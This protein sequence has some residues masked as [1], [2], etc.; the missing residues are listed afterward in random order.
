MLLLLLRILLILQELDKNFT[1]IYKNRLYF[2]EGKNSHC[3]ETK[4]FHVYP[5]LFIDDFV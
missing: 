3:A 1:R 4:L 2:E 5:H